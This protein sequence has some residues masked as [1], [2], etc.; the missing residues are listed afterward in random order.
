MDRTALAP[1]TRTSMSA[2]PPI[3]RKLTQRWELCLYIAGQNEKTIRAMKN[4]RSICE[5]YLSREEYDLVVVDLLL[6]PQIAD[7]EQ[8]LA[9]PMLVRQS[10]KPVRRIVGDLSDR[11]VVEIAL[12]LSETAANGH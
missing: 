7:R 12:N 9:V 11:Q 8:I 4:V 3:K 2:T 5:Q 6:D 10:P 1:S